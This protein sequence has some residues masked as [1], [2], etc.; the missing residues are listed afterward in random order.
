MQVHTVS[1]SNTPKDIKK[2][3]IVITIYCKSVYNLQKKDKL[4]NELT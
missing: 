3:V 1:I 2:I 4:Q